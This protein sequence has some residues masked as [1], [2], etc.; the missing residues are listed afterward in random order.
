MIDHL[1]D[2]HN[3]SAR[4]ILIS[5]ILI[6]SRKQPSDRISLKFTIFCNKSYVCAQRV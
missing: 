5:I 1:H 3:H 2:D 4:I 6:L